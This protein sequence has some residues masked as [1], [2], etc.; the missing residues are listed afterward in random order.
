MVRAA[1]W[2]VGL[3][4]AGAAISRLF[5]A[6]WM[7]PLLLVALGVAF[8]FVSRTRAATASAGVTPLPSR[9]ATP[10]AAAVPVEQSA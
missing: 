2:C 4:G 6:P 10:A 7:Q 1:G 8:L 3:F 5:P 9:A